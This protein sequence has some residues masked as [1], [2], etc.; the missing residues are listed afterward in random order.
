MSR[1]L[2]RNLRTQDPVRVLRSATQTIDVK[3]GDFRLKPRAGV[4]YDGLYRVT[5]YSVRKEKGEFGRW[6]FE[7]SLE[8]LGNQPVLQAAMKAPTVEQIRASSLDEDAHETD[9]YEVDEQLAKVIDSRSASGTSS[10]NVF[11]GPQI[12]LSPIGAQS[13]FS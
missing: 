9:M 1:K 10:L 2:L 7:F 8:R 13:P 5:G 3:Q 11:N 6:R 12:S 4:R